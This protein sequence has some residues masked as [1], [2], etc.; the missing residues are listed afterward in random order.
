MTASEL[1]ST[2]LPLDK[3]FSSL[4]DRWHRKQW[5][6]LLIAP[7]LVVPVVLVSRNLGEQTEGVEAAQALLV[8]TMRLRLV[9]GYSTNRVY[10]GEL[11]ARRSSE[12]GFERA[13]TVTTLLVDE[14][15]VVAAG[16][17]LARLDTRDLQAQR[18]Q[19]E[20]Q[21]RQVLAQLDELNTGPRSEDIAAAE[22]AVSDLNNQLSLATLQANRRAELYD[23]GAI[24]REELDER[25]FGAK[26]IAD[27]LQQAQSQLEALQNGTRKEQITAQAAQVDRI[28]AQL[29]EID[30]AI[31]KSV[32]LA[33]FAGEVA[34]RAVD[35]GTVV[36]ASQQVMKLVEKG[37]VEARIGVPESVAQRLSVGDHT[38]VQ[39]GSR[40]HPATVTAQLPEVDETSQTVTIVLELAPDDD[41]TIGATARL[42]V[43]EQQ[44]ASG[45]WLPS[46]ALIAGDQGLWSV[47][48]LEKDQAAEA[49]RVTRRDVEVLHTEGEPPS[50]QFVDQS[51]DEADS[52]SRNGLSS[53][54][55]FVR[56]LVAEGDRIIAAGTHR[57]VA[58]QLVKPEDISEETTAE[59]AL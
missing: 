59:E 23:Q 11:A 19:L 6:W 56:G 18:S 1:D 14:G 49:Y 58:S 35:E 8:E 2:N 12:L 45:Y 44:T 36:S 34:A 37:S 10:S 51:I 30:V 57:V 38:A 24:S 48:V 4:R 5:Q 50:G 42:S 21:R 47:Y 15:G 55:A 31:D 33:P 26:A 32:L 41:L 25:E 22:G 29:E 16:E 46:T 52:L 39:V 7:L 54:R 27:R 40:V 17:P 43:A 13:G 53:N 28:D 9:E 3:P 20:A